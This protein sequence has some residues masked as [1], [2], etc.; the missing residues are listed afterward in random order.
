VFKKNIILLIFFLN[1]LFN[2]FSQTDTIKKLNLDEIRSYNKIYNPLAPS[3]AAFYSAVFPGGGQIFNKKYWKVPIVWTA[4][5]TSTY[6]YLDNNREYK[7]YR[8]A[9]KQRKNGLQDEFT[10]DDGSEIISITGLERA[11]KTL[12]GNRDLSIL[13]TL[14][15]YVL[16]IVEA[17]VNAHLLQFDAS[18]NISINPT[19]IN[20]LVKLDLPSLG[21]SFKYTF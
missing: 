10:L 16:Q 21:F 17:S 5:G 14:L 12:R 3:K 15:I 9:Y 6:F 4:L 2:C 13:S 8:T 20:D 1:C 7:R 11:Q 19:M 18:N